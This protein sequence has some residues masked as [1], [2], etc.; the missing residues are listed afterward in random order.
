M[1]PIPALLFCLLLLPAVAPAA[2]PVRLVVVVSVDQLRPDTLAAYRDE[3]QGGLGR[4]LKHARSFDCVHDHAITFTGPGHSVL[5]TGLHPRRTGIA[6]NHWRDP[7]TLR[8]VYCVED[9]EHRVFGDPRRTASPRLLRCD[10]LGDWMRRRNPRSKVYSVAGKDRSAVLM[11]GQHPGAALWYDHVRGGFTSS[12]YYFPY[13][14]PDWVDAF[15]NDGWLRSLPAAWTYEPSPHLRRDDDPRES[16][17]NNRASP[18]PLRTGMLMR[19][20]S[21]IYGSPYLD[22]WTLR[23]ARAL[24]ERHDLGGDE[25]PDLL[26]IGLSATDTVGHLYGPRSQEIRDVVL[27][28]DRELGEFFAFLD[29]RGAPYVVAL[30]ADHGV[31]ALDDLKAVN[32][33]EAGR[34]VKAALQERLGAG[35]WT[36]L[37]KHG[38]SPAPNLYLDRA[39]CAERGV[40]PERVLRALKQVLSARPEVAAVYDRA[41][42]SGTEATDDVLLAL[43]R[44][45]Y[46]PG[47]TGDLVF[48]TK[49]GVLYRTGPGTSHGS[50]YAYDREVPLLFI[51]P[52]IEPGPGGA[53]RTI[54]LGPTLAVLLGLEPPADLDGAP[55]A[56]R[57]SR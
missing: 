21:N 19:T 44:N 39:L 20:L 52:G 43:A 53:A 22:E 9:A 1:S 45:S 28:L 54:D 18:H 8:T 47:R 51:G 30:C 36:S 35:L 31:L 16:P 38:G 29:A 26:C 6:L 37:H 13:G 48:R 2:E 11:G 12:T 23:F 55:L 41:Q 24:V 17:R 10:A 15:R 56:L 40:A 33:T 46:A 25:A 34:E 27:H 50:P 57:G 5:L 7:A 32:G 42:L 14:L 4:L 49:P 3:Y